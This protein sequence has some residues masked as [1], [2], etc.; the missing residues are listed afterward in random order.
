MLS[1]AD[2]V[3]IVQLYYENGKS[4]TVAQRMFSTEMNIK[5]KSDSPSVQLVADI[6]RKFEENGCVNK[7]HSGHPRAVSSSREAIDEAMEIFQAR[8][9]VPSIRKLSE[10]SGSSYGTVQKHLRKELHLYPYKYTIGQVLTDEHKGKRYMF[11]GW[12]LHEVHRDATFLSRIIWS[13]ECSFHLDGWVNR[14]NLR[15]WGTERPTEVVEKMTQSPKVNVWMAMTSSFVIGPYFFEH[16]G[17]TATINSERYLALLR[18][19]LLP[20]LE[21]K[22][23]FRRMLFQQD[24]ASPHVSRSV[25]EFLQQKIGLLKVISRHFPRE[26]PP[27]SP[28]L[29]PLDFW[30]WSFI[31]EK[32]YPR[33]NR[34]NNKADLKLR[35]E[36][37]VQEITVSHLEAVVGNVEVRMQ[38]CFD[39][40]GSHFE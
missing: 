11:S 16:E 2:R 1:A 12:I 38:K 39:C 35:I 18:D 17:T 8:G 10:A 13:D 37:A 7:E 25:K 3:R 34:P 29:T 30:M 9:E 15:F 19:Y 23:T 22:P 6:I 4:Y 14:Q 20:T 28:D 5:R 33:G 40:E 24:G 32:V 31:K 27:Y 36:N 26:W 21:E